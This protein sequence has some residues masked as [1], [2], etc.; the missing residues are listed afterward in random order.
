MKSKVRLLSLSFEPVQQAF[1]PQTAGVLGASYSHLR[2]HD[3]R[4]CKTILSSGSA[5]SRTPLLL[6]IS[7]SARPTRANCSSLPP[8]RLPFAG[9]CFCPTSHSRVGNVSLLGWLAAQRNSVTLH[10][11]DVYA[12]LK[13]MSGP[14]NGRSLSRATDRHTYWAPAGTVELDM[15]IAGREI[16]D[17]KHGVIYRLA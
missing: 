10:E 11:G 2:L 12:L 17:A 4:L 9:H 13:P 5:I 15:A 7:A 8:F 14:C 6:S 3:M 1:K 16:P